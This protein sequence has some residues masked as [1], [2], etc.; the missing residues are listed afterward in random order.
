[1]KRKLPFVLGL[2]I[3]LVLLCGLPFLPAEA[4]SFGDFVYTVS[5]G[6]AT[7][8]GYNGAGGEVAIP[9]TVNGNTVVAIGDSAF[10]GQTGITGI[11]I[12]KTVT[13]I[14]ARVLRMHGIDKHHDPRKSRVPRYLCILRLH[15]RDGTA[16]QRDQRALFCEQQIQ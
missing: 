16:L 7:I 5:D 11:T 14:G 15:K 9:E 6:N 1:M 2:G 10:S 3:L 4:E 13:S 12:P 8:T